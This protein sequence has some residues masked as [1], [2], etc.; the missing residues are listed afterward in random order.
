[1]KQV[2]LLY[3][4]GGTGKSLAALQLAAATAL[5]RDWLGMPLDGQGPALFFSAEDDAEELHHRL[6]G[7]ARS[8]GVGLDQL[9]AL[10]WASLAGEDAML[11]TFPN[12]DA[13]LKRTPLF[14]SLERNMAK[15]GPKLL[16]LDTL[17]DLF[18]GDENDKAQPRQ[19]V[20]LLRGLA[21]QHE[22][23]VVLLAHP[24]K[25][26]MTN[27]TGDSGSVAWS[28]SAR[29]R[30][31]MQRVKESDGYEPNPDARVLTTMKA[32]YGP[33]GAE[34]HV[35]WR[36][37]VFAP[38]S[39]GAVAAGAGDRAAKAKRVF[40]KLLE[41]YLSEGR[42]VNPSGGQDYAPRRFAEHPD[43]E[44][45]TQRAFTTAMDQLLD[46]GEIVV[47][48]DGPPSKRR[49]F[50][51]P[52]DTTRRGAAAA[53]DGGDAAAAGDGGDGGET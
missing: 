14:A 50:L 23:A 24:S 4:D 42:R 8:Y 27:R 47:E 6:D 35:E 11:A 22:C 44:G 13:M 33:A 18:G 32:N 9:D 19:F 45:V 5:G 3:G 49:R 51:A 7:V 38:V 2:T 28:N 43:S 10:Q 17:N 37:G 31:Y 40:R 39:G 34:V 52:R 46:S 16:V 48:E 41:Q 29:S 21:I 20:Q 1:M 25:S 26:G 30:L 36:A 53:G 15:H 12:R